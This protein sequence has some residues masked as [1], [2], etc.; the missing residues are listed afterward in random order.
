MKKITLI[1]LSLL[2]GT[3]LTSCSNRDIIRS[4]DITQ[5]STP[6]PS[7]P[8]DYQKT[9][10]S[11]LS[12]LPKNDYSLSGEYEWTKD[13][14]ETAS[15]G[16]IS[17]SFADGAYKYDSTFNSQNVDILFYK[18]T[19]GDNA[20]NKS[21]DKDNNVEEEEYKDQDNQTYVYSK[22]ESPFASFNA[23]DFEAK[24][25]TTATLKTNKDNYLNAASALTLFNVTSIDS[26]S[27]SLSSSSVTG[28]TFE[29]KASKRF[30]GPTQN[31]SIKATLSFDSKFTA[32]YIPEKYQTHDYDATLTSAFDAISNGTVTLTSNRS[33]NST[34]DL[35]SSLKTQTTYISYDKKAYLE[36]STTLNSTDWTDKGFKGYFLPDGEKV[37]SLEYKNNTWSYSKD[38]YL[39]GG[40]N[41]DSLSFVIPTR[42]FPVQ[43]FTYD[44]A[45]KTYKVAKEE[46]NDFASFYIPYTRD[47]AATIKDIDSGS[48]ALGTDNKI[49]NITFGS[50]AHKVTYSIDI[51]YEL[52][53]PFDETKI[54]QT[55]DKPESTSNL[56]GTFTVNYTD[57][58][59]A[60]ETP[61]TITMV[62]NGTDV[63][64]DRKKATD[65]TRAHDDT[66]QTEV[67]TFTVDGVTWKFY[68]LD[69]Y[70][71]EAP[72][73]RWMQVSSVEKTA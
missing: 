72:D 60:P 2:A 10:A 15:K 9:F 39:V 30:N 5:E 64:W 53:L 8:E 52:T 36:S 4:S 18:P 41:Q 23:A 21:I 71:L 73:A 45:S 24:D 68:F 20:V 1:T 12:S 32:P 69:I 37:R 62:I 26:L 25:G 49:T 66:Y 50:S 59:N 47:D 31:G 61:V 19:T 48:I 34:S 51:K 17:V 27:L 57:Y 7:T 3:I 16:D 14:D 40:S 6:T 33:V 29:G 70:N 44:E 38:A 43:A 58:Q 65:V 55:E 63:T 28:I 54:A 13:G 56:D 46:A 35:A 11:S 42:N 67:I 22:Y